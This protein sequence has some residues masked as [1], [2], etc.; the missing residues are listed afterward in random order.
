MRVI[1]TLTGIELERERWMRK[2]LDEF[3]QAG[4]YAALP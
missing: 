4:S 3:A 2:K 1:C